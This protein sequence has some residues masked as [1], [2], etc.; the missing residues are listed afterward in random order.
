MHCSL[1]YTSS[2]VR[3]WCDNSLAQLFNTTICT[4]YFEK[5]TQC[6]KILHPIMQCIRLFH[7]RQRISMHI[8]N[9][10]F[11][12]YLIRLPKIETFLHTHKKKGWQMQNTLLTA[13][14]NQCNE[15]MMWQQRSIL[16]FKMI[17]KM[18]SCILKKINKY[19]VHTLQKKIKMHSTMQCIWFSYYKFRISITFLLYWQ[20]SQTLRRC[21][22]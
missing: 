6:K 15:V 18:T 12:H 20:N 4:C 8:F 3:L 5:N 11:T 10:S 7:Y 16:L 22:V 2:V 1:H 9:I 13:L 17:F 14:H 19:W 21:I